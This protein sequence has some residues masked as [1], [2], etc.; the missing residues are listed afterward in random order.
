M[1]HAVGTLALNGTLDC[2]KWIAAFKLDGSKSMRLDSAFEIADSNGSLRMIH[3][4]K[5][6][7]SVPLHGIL[8]RTH[9]LTRNGRFA[10]IEDLHAEM[11]KAMPAT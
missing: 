4:C 11:R 7:E 9:H 8:H 3:V 5:P 1:E 6:G 2:W 10:N